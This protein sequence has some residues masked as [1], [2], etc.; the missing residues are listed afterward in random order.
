MIGYILSAGSGSRIAPYNEVRPKALLP[1]LNRPLVSYLVDAF[2][3][4]PCTE[5]RLAAHMGPGDL[6]GVVPQSVTVTDVGETAGTA[7]SLAAIY[8]PGASALVVPGDIIVTGT[9]TGAGARF[10]PPRFLVPGDEIVVAAE[11]IGEL[12]NGVADE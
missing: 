4:T 7:E 9:P 5:L 10:D 3:A 8:D 1:I 11:G 2:E 12:R 6:R